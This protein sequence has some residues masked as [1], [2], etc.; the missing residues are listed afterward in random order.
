MSVLYSNLTVAEFND[1]LEVE[2]KAD[3]KQLFKTQSDTAKI[4]NLISHTPET[5]LY[6]RPRI[7]LYSIL[8]PLGICQ[9]YIRSDIFNWHVREPFGTELQWLLISQI[10]FPFCVHRLITFL[11]LQVKLVS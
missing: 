10:V 2:M 3:V 7:L 8:K 9:N 6:D 1:R 4:D 11:Q 5:F